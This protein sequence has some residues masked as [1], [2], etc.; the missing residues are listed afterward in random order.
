MQYHIEAIEIHTI[1]ST[2]YKLND[3]PISVFVF[4]ILWN[5]VNISLQNFYLKEAITNYIESVIMIIHGRGGGWAGVWVSV[6]TP[7]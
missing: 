4:G 5:S 3:Q 2:R 1:F 6:I 7:C